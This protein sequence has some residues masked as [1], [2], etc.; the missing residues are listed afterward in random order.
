MKEIQNT[1]H[2]LLM[3]HITII[4]IRFKRDLII[5]QQLPGMAK[6]II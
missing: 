4:I 1:L 3:I 5:Q 6:I 2:R